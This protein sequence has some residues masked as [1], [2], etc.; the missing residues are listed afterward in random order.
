[1]DD[2]QGAVMNLS[3]CGGDSEEEGIHLHV[4]DVLP[5]TP[6]PSF[7]LLALLLFPFAHLCCHLGPKDAQE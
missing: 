3:L 6:F 7:L 2:L 5:P 1:M 4:G